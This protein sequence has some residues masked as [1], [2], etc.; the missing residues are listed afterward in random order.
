EETFRLAVR[1]A[2]ATPFLAGA[3]GRG[4]CASFDWLVANESNVGKGVARGYEGPA[5]RLGGGSG[6]G[7]GR[8]GGGGTG[9]AGGRGRV[10]RV[11]IGPLAAAVGA[12]VK[13]A[14]LER[15]RAREQQRANGG[16]G[17]AS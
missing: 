7:W 14:A 4:W 15:I 10:G 12:R 9:I 8:R 17:K 5:A 1:Q 6:G 3:G 2:A 13:P 16:E 11:G